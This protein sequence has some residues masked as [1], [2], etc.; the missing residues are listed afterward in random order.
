MALFKKENLGDILEEEKRLK[1]RKS[2]ETEI[3]SA[4]ER[5]DKLRREVKGSGFREGL[6]SVGQGLG[7][8]AMAIQRFAQ[9]RAEPARTIPLRRPIKSRTVGRK[10]GKKSTKNPLQRQP[11]RVQAPTRND[12]PFGIRD[13]LRSG[14]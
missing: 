4:R 11:R 2:V 1:A 6:I 14:I 5:R 8:G 7:R 3:R 9:S 12:D 10:I 13:A